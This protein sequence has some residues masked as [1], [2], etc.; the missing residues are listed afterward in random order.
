M[1]DS[2]YPA[3]CQLL[4][5]WDFPGKNTGMGCNFLLQGT[6][7][8]QG[9]NPHL[10]HWQACSLPL[11]QIAFLIVMVL[12]MIRILAKQYP[13]A[14]LLL[15]LLKKTNSKLHECK[16]GR[17]VHQQTFEHLSCGRDAVKWYGAVH[18][19]IWVLWQF[20]AK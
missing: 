1:S 9:S 10:L 6:F 18:Q 2:L 17:Q 3:V 14:K 4:C 8:T 12:I 19:K 15:P 5:P 13:N 11:S 20:A 7:P 16:R